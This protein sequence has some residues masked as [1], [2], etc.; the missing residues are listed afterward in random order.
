MKYCFQNVEELSRFSRI[1]YFNTSKLIP[2]I[3]K[4]KIPT[5]N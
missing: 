4:K 1:E 3:F 5:Y 2:L